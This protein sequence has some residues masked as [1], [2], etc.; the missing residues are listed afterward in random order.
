[1]AE[2]PALLS[3]WYEF[4]KWLL[5]R[6]DQFP[7]NQRFILGQRLVDGALD[8]QECLV[9]AACSGGQQKS[10]QLATANRKIEVLRWLIRLAH[11]RELL[12]GRQ[13]AFSSEQMTECG[14]MLGGWIKQAGGPDEA[15]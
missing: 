1:M 10:E 5:G 6:V 7:K 14:R 11:E 4:S 15:P 2:A 8:I 12:S 9:E 3:K 13:F